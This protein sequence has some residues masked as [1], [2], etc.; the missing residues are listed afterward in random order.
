MCANMWQEEGTSR[1][2]EERDEISSSISKGQPKG[3][4]ARDTERMG[5]MWTKRH[6]SAKKQKTTSAKTNLTKKGKGGEWG[7]KKTRRP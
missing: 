1:S 7:R 3:D 6:G 2:E 4:L 5:N